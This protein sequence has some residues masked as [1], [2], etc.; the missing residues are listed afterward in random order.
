MW[1]VGMVF[2]VW[3]SVPRTSWRASQAWHGS[4]V[5]PD[6]VLSMWKLELVMQA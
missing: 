3:I 4:I 6:L 5:C 1:E 2:P